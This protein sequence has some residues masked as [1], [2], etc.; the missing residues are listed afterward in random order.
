LLAT[1]STFST[2]RTGD[3]PNRRVRK[4]SGCWER[5][6]KETAVRLEAA[7][8]GQDEP[9]WN[10]A[11]Q[12]NSACGTLTLPQS[13]PTSPALANLSAFRLDPR[14]AALAGR[15]GATM[16]RYADDLA[17]SGDRAFDRALPCAPQ[18]KALQLGTHETQPPVQVPPQPSAAPVRVR[19]RRRRCPGRAPSRAEISPRL[20]SR[21]APPRG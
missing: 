10:E 15:F 18:S 1:D 20:P 17:F 6:E 12:E 2:I 5:C 11:K 7:V 19:S 9:D 14:L 16:T 4:L 3:G 8:V 13:A 21:C